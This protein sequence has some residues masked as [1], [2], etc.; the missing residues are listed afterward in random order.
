MKNDKTNVEVINED[1][2]AQFCNEEEDDVITM[3]DNI[4]EDIHN[5]NVLSNDFIVVKND[6]LIDICKPDIF[7]SKYMLSNNARIMDK[8]KFD[9]VFV[10]IK[11][12]LK[13]RLE[14]HGS[15][16]LSS[17]HEI[18]GILTEEMKEL[19]D[20]IHENNSENIESEL[21]D[22]LIA[23]FFGLVSIYSKTIKW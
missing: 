15:G 18:Y 1:N 23:A 8:S 6:K 16:G 4:G 10:N 21:Y 9:I 5:V 2:F 3:L 19:L 22:V 14:K 13:K 12:L 17:T 7:N 11:A 20:S